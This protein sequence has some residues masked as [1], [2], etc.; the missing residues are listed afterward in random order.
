MHSHSDIQSS[1][2]LLPKDFDSLIEESVTFIRAQEEL[3]NF[4]FWN[5]RSPV[6]HFLY[7]LFRID[8]AI[9]RINATI[10]E[11]FLQHDCDCLD[12]QSNLLRPLRRRSPAVYIFRFVR[13]LEQSGRICCSDVLAEGAD[14]VDDLLALLHDEG[15][16]P[17]TIRHY[18][19]VCLNLIVWLHFSRLKLCE[20]TPEIIAQFHQRK[21]TCTIP[22]VF[23]RGGVHCGTKWRNDWV[24]DRFIKH[25]VQAGQIEFFE[26][27]QP[28][29][30]PGILKRFSLWLQRHRGN[31]EATRDKHVRLIKALLPDLGEDPRHYD[32]ALIRKVVFEHIGSGCSHDYACRVVVSIR[33]YLRFLISE[34]AV[35]AS[36]LGSLPSFPKSSL[37]SLPRFISQNDVERAIQT[38]DNSPIGVRDRAI[39]LLLA[40]LALRAQ[41]IIDLRIDD[42][43]WQ[44]ARIRVSGKSRQ[45]TE[46]PL[47]QDVGDALYAYLSI[48]RP[49]VQADKV[50]ICARAPW[51]PLGKSN[52][53]SSLARKALDRAGIVTH[54]TRGAHV[55]R[56]SQATNLLRDGASLDTIQTL[57]RHKNADSTAI[58]AKTDVAMLTEV[59]QPWI[60]EVAQ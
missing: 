27:P 5:Y 33:M 46:L 40:R 59:A 2:R 15:Y 32:A 38:C 50:F 37:A 36:L 26:C 11:S 39:L 34:G 6:R 19:A 23:N 42:I 48:A 57:L 16:A 41:D 35:G 12:E 8:C 3:S 21:L 18:R 4:Y 20:L 47:P 28:E 29:A 10:I 43:D 60:A 14:R 56:H 45:Q 13:F 1:T 17:A 52:I 22:G 30:I 31:R 54:A 58:Y 24:I 51:R 55:F 9:G 25:L 44:R 53:V 49:P 7:W